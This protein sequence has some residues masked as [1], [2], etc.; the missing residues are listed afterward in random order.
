MPSAGAGDF[1]RRCSFAKPDNVEDEF[2]N[3]TAGW[4]TMFEVWANITPRLGGETVEAARLTGRQPVVVRVR[5]TPDTITIRTDW[6][7]TDTVSGIT[8]NVR[9]ISDPHLGDLE[10]GK[11]LDILAEAGVAI[12][13][14]AASSL[15]GVAL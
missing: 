10:H 13:A 9:A 15:Q 5:K 6:M 14:G 2:G 4:Q 8:Y 7:I 12:G 3:V 11:W 1:R